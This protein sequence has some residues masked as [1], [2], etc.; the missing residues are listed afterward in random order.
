MQIERRLVL[1]SSELRAAPD[2][3]SI[4]G[5]AARY[6]TLSMPLQGNGGTF[7]ERISPGAF[8]SALD[9]KQDVTLLVNHDTDQLLGRTASGTL[10]LRDTAAGLAFS[11]DLPDTQLGR[12]THTMIQRGDLNGCS[13]GFAL[14]K[15]DA[16]WSEEDIEDEDDL[17]GSD[18]DEKKQKRAARKKTSRQ[19]VRTITNVSKLFDVSVVARPAYPKGTSVEA[20]GIELV[21]AEIPAGIRSA[22]ESHATRLVREFGADKVLDVTFK[23]GQRSEAVRG[24]RRNLLNQ[25]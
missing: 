4:T 17:F 15:R 21:C 5:L 16:D 18:E 7:R 8:R 25:V 20:R 6:N 3:R 9:S 10:Q 19:A 23:Q 24:R 22:I 13:F 12:D 14:G 1:L 2:G 11:C